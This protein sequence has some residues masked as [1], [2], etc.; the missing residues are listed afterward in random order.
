MTPP[1][2]TNGEVF[3]RKKAQ[4]AQKKNNPEEDLFYF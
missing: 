1:K 3:R 4:K 2:R